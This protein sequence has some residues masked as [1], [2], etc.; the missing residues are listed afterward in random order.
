MGD[1]SRETLLTAEPEQRRQMLEAY[2]L[3]WLLSSLKLSPTKL[4]PQQPFASLLDSLLA[5]TFRSR[6][7]ADLQV[8]APMEQ[9]FGENTIAQLA[10]QLLNQLALANLTEQ[11][12]NTIKD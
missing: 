9:F 2:L 12:S 7:E 1:F 5:L 6:I 8:Q 10:D 3:R 4:T 11:A